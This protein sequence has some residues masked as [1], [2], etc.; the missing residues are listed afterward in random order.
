MFEGLKIIVH[1]HFL[2]EYV[3]MELLACMHD[4]QHFFLNLFVTSFDV[5]KGTLGI[6]NK[7]AV[8]NEYRTEAM[9]A[10]VTLFPPA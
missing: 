3:R 10:C 5:G 6:G 2:A 8:L 9:L 4:G 7:L 1:G